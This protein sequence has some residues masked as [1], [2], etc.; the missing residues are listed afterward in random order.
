MTTLRLAHSPDSDDLVMWWPLTGMRGPDGSPVAGPLGTPRIDTEG[1][2]F[3]LVAEDVEALNAAVRGEDGSLDITAISAA[4][5]PAVKDRFA[6]TR[7]G[8]SFG[9][10]YGPKVVVSEGSPIASLEDLRG[11]KIAVPGLGTSAFLTLS[12]ALGSTPGKAAFTP[13]PML[14]SDVP[15]AVISG[16]CDAGLLIHEAQ[17]T[18]AD[19]GL[20]AVVD[21]GQWWGG[22][23]DL[24]LPLGLNVI[25]R[26]LDKRVDG[27]MAKVS[28]VLMR[29]VEYATS[30]AKESQEY[31]LLHSEDRPEWRDPA[32]VEKYLSMYVSRMSLDMSDRG[33]MAL[34][35]FLG[36]GHESGLCLDAGTIEVV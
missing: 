36:D 28:R 14:F 2:A 11:K 1:L 31:L 35:R 23:T 8:G 6:I 22:Q 24:P 32:L 3:E 4:T 13:E 19:L 30:H 29:S 21:L 9:E 26:D 15:G 5:Y 16:A 33:L 20:R 12:M 17:L 7:C 25:R 10:G 34:R 18:F 27:G